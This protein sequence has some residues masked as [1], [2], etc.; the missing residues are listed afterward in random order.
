MASR[1][2]SDRFLFLYSKTTADGHCSHEIRRWLHLGRK[3]MTNLASML[4][5]KD[6]TL[7]TNV[8]IVKTM[9]GLSSSH[10]QMWKLDHKEGKAPKSWYFRTVLLEKILES[11]LDSK[12]I[13]PVNLKGSQ[14]WMFIGRPPDAKSQLIGKDSDAGKDW[15]QKKKGKQRIRWLDNITDSTNMNLSKLQELVKDRRARHAAVHGAAKSQ[16][17]VGDRTITTEAIESHDSIWAGER[18]GKTDCFSNL[19]CALLTKMSPCTCVSFV[20]SSEKEN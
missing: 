15:G 1:R 6:I 16:T 9:Y 19:G 11:L 13:K 4:K 17:W 8:P 3:A 18:H 10:A 20:A 14:P 7:L 5:S 12:E 2:A